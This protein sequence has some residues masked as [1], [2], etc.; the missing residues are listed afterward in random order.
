M[1]VRGQVPAKL[2]KTAGSQRCR[3]RLPLPDQHSCPPPHFRHLLSWLY[4]MAPLASPLPLQI[5]YVV[6]VGVVGAS[7]TNLHSN[8]RCFVTLRRTGRL[9]GTRNGPTT[10]MIF[11]TSTRTCTVATTNSSSMSP[12][13]RLFYGTPATPRLPVNPFVLHENRL[14]GFFSPSIEACPDLMDA[15]KSHNSRAPAHVLTY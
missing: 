4:R 12:G 9:P 1:H 14:L 13:A 3:Q 15:G 8:V 10:S 2:R 11:P 7:L 6:G 5:G